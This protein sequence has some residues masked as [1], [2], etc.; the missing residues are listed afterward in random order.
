MQTQ[1]T[2]TKR[3]NQQH[4]VTEPIAG[5]ATETDPQLSERLIDEIDDLLTENNGAG[6]AALIT[7]VR[8]EKV[9][10]FKGRTMT[11]ARAWTL[12]GRVD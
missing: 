1:A 3:K 11:G 2:K 10:V 12:G 9:Q 6:D 5:T 8:N 4:E 7:S